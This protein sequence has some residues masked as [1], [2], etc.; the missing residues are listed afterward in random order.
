MPPKLVT[1]VEADYP[2][3]EKASGREASVVL[4]LGISETGKVVAVVVE[5]SAGTAFDTA[6]VAA[7]RQLVF[8]PASVDGKPIPV[9]I[10][11][12]YAF[13]VKQEVVQR[14]NSDFVGIVRDR[15][16]KKPLAGVNIKLETGQSAVT[17][18]EGRF[19]IGEV[20]PGVHS[21]TL[22]GEGLTKI[23]TQETFEAGKK[24]EAIYDVDVKSKDSGDDDSD[25]EIVVTAPRIGKQVIST[26]IP[27]EQGRKVPGSQGDVLKVVENL[28]G[29]ARAA[30]GSG[31]LVVWGAAPED[32]QVF[33]EGIRI[34]RLYHDGGYRSVLH[35][36]MVK[37]VELVPGGYGATYGRGIG[38]LVTVQLRPFW[39][40]E[41]VHGSV[42]V[43]VI[44]ASASI[45]A[46]ITDKLYAAA[47]VRRSH[48]DAVIRAVGSDDVGDVVPLPKYED[49]QARIVYV[50]DKNETLEIG[51]LYSS[52]RI[53]RTLLE[54]D[55][56]DTK[57]ESRALD[58]GRIYARYE[59]K[60]KDGA[61]VALT[62]SWGRNASRI[63]NRFGSTPTELTNDA[64]VFAVRGS[65]RAQPLPW[66]AVSTGL[67]V[68]V[69]A[70]SLRRAGSV[71]SPARE[72]D[73]RVFGQAP[74]DQVNVDRWNTVISSLAPYGE[75]DVGL[76]D[77]K[78]H[79]VPGV[80]LEPY[81]LSVDKAVPVSGDV[82]KSGASSE[83][84]VVE[85]RIAVRYQIAPRM[86]VKA[87]FGI[88]HQPPGAEDLS[89]VFGNPG[90][91][92]AQARH[93][94]IGT[95]V[96]LTP[97]LTTEVTAFHSSMSDLVARS[98]APTP[99]LAEALV[100][101][102]SGK[103]Y[104][105]QFLL[106]Q[107]QVGRFFGWVSYSIIRSLRTAGPGL[108]ERLFDYDQSH[109]FTA[110]GSY[111]LG[112]GFEVGLRGRFA[113][114]YPRTPV[115]GS[116]YSPRTDRFEPIFGAQNTS[117]IPAFMQLDARIA[118]R[119]KIGRTE[120]ELY[121]D[122][123]NVTNRSNAEEVVYGYDYKQK[124]YITGLPILPVL[125]CKWTF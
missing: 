67:D 48:L 42:A 31:A 72:G 14:T 19:T 96:K 10:S 23:G 91:G 122:V 83:H 79:V 110:V 65:Y 78:L 32:T 90:L 63:T 113:T 66:L 60:L 6:A 34:P 109:V 117:R 43:D 94:L 46:K 38:G 55:P 120:A 8:E 30:V 84:T 12:R 114:G 50:F 15:A 80:R 11:Y 7:A 44:D 124:A 111:D 106:R 25:F 99:L 116:Y 56:A 57:R 29:V 35:S 9:K 74:S 73:V 53:Q 76:F 92:L 68:D 118:K 87:A 86:L 97:S 112:A 2:E 82:P 85:P 54:P 103:S 45:S 59:K 33:V 22:E 102:G 77:D 40:K 20:D 41:G 125:G 69:T 98:T 16:S 104:G 81:V 37:S 105:V 27:A 39:E 123:Q 36:D 119:F 89:A 100:Q 5:A 64:D 13:A 71:S 70:S 1:F 108:D 101:Q 62:P 47:A 24:L 28:P 61:V 88:Y 51:G 107:E 95:S 121:L 58:F 49:S 3:S 21:V 26:E 93:A 52:D 4:S 115:I 18:G 75:A 17:D